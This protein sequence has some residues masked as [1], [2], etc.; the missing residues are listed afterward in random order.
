[1]F[2]RG[3]VSERS[4]RMVQLALDQFDEREMMITDQMIHTFLKKITCLI[5]IMIVV[6]R[7]TSMTSS[8]RLTMRKPRALFSEAEMRL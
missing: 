7:E 1:M 8:V 5:L 2:P 4:K 3:G 6:T